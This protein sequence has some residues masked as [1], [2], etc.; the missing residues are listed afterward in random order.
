MPSAIPTLGIIEV[1]IEVNSF[2]KP[3]RG[4]RRRL[5][6]RAL[7]PIVHERA[8][9]PRSHNPTVACEKK[10]RPAMQGGAVNHARTGTLRR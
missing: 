1:S 7:R 2:D 3:F 6:L 10:H 9:L 8:A 5:Q 4:C